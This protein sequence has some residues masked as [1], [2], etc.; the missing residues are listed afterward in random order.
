MRGGGGDPQGGRDR[1]AGLRGSTE[2]WELLGL[3]AGWGERGTEAG[4]GLGAR[5]RV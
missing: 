2:G 1:G 3:E 5:G 4:A